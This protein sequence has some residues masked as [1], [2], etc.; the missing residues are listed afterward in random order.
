MYTLFMHPFSQHSRRVVA[1]LEAEGLPYKARRIALEQ[2]EHMTADYLAINPNHQVPTLIDGDLK[3][4]ESTAI[5][6]YLCNRH[7]LETWYPADHAVRAEVDQWMDWGQSRMAPAVTDIVYHSMFADAQT[8]DR[9]AIERG[10]ARMAE[11]APMIETRL[12]DR[13]WIAGTDAPTIADLV[14]ASNISQLGL[15]GWRP[16]S[17][18]LRDWYG[19]MCELKAFAATL[20]EMEGA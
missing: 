13:D 6:R 12:A 16:A 3:L 9:A 20:P 8:R 15:A 7:A 5:L 1:L 18:H 10:K 17:G 4:H 2:G 11:L 14:V 19:R